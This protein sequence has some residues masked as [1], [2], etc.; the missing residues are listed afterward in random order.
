[1]SNEQWAMNNEQ[2]AVSCQPSAVSFQYQLLNPIT[3]N[4]NQEKTNP[5]L[6]L[7]GGVAQRSGLRWDGV[8]WW[9]MNNE[10]L[11]M[12]G[13]HES[14]TPTFPSLYFPI[15]NQRLTRY[16]YALAFLTS[17]ARMVRTFVWTKVPKPTCGRQAHRLGMLRGPVF[18]L[19]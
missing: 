4:L 6:P 13:R 12:T 2:L 9:A 7:R 14:F 17:Q 8:G 10:Q 1:M 5:N 3:V 16:D 15:T 11:A 19:A 18:G